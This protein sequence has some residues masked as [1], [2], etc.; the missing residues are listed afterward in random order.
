MPELS[1]SPSNSSIADRKT[2][3]QIPPEQPSPIRALYKSEDELRELAASVARGEELD[4][5]GYQAFEFDQRLSENGKLILHAYRSSDAASRAGETI[6]PAAQWLLDNH[7][8]IDK[9]V[10][11]TRRDLPRKFIR[12]LPPYEARVEKY[13][14]MPRIFALAW[15][16]VAHTDSNFSLK[17]LTALVQ[18]FQ[19]VEPLKIG[20]LWALPSAVRYFLIENARRLALRV[21]RARNMRNLANTAA[22]RIVVA[23]DKDELDTV[24]AQYAQAARDS[25]FA[26]H[27]LYRLRSASTDTSAA[28]SWLERI[29]EQ[30]GSNPED[31][32]VEEHARQSTGGVTM[33]N[34][35]TSLK[36]IDDIDWET[37][38]ETVNEV[39]AIL[40]DHS[41][42]E[43]LDFRS[44]N[45]YRVTIEKLARF[46]NM[47]E[48]DIT[49]AAL[50]LAEDS[51]SAGPADVNG[52]EGKG[53]IA[54]Y[55]SGEGRFEL[56]KMCGYKAPFGV[57]AL[58]FYRNLGL[59]GFF[60]PTAIFTILILL[61]VNYC[62]SRAGL[63][64]DLRTLFTLL[65][66]FPAMD[67][68]Y[69]LFNALV[70]WF[71]QPT[72]LIGFE[73]KEGL[74]VEARTLVAVPTLINSRDSIDEQI[75]N[76]EVHYL[77]N[78]RGEIY[79]ALVSDW[80]DAKQEIT[81]ADME[82]YEY[83]LP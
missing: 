7:Y 78:P 15:L 41:D 81:P 45:A 42:F 61:T 63:S 6:T 82:I 32:I 8:Q 10:Q 55:L 27:L 36:R 58:R 3:D 53:S 29:L 56:E 70:P 13:Q 5:P 9:T 60:I 67:A 46:S 11:Q 65:A 4:L 68:S 38:F 79:F 12:Q 28:A 72:R 69:S 19:T 47:S 71:V 48:I 77:T 64:T 35:I 52:A 51:K 40:R 16:Y 73:Y 21:D 2:S 44:R 33:G 30:E 59:L 14:D 34:V 57:K 23:T 26:T 76:L 1:S 24:L 66:I 39:D 49:W 83:A 18:G 43:L 74:P 20:E 17:S 25:T 54:Y 50:K 80:V 62:M 37:W 31:A 75:R 22:D